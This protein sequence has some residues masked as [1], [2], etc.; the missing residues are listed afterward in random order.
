MRVVKTIKHLRQILSQARLK[1]QKIGFVPTMGYLHEGHLS[2]MRQARQE[3]AVCVVSI[4]VNP[5]QFG[6]HEDF[7]HYPRDIKRDATMVKKENVD[8][9]FIPSDNVIYSNSYLTYIDVEKMSDRLCGKYRPGHFKG[10]ATIVAK[11]LNMVRPDIMYLGQKDAQQVLIL[12][13]MVADLNFPVSIRVVPTVRAK[14]GLAISSRNV[15]LSSDQRLQAPVLYR[16][17]KSARVCVREGERRASYITG[18]IR[19]II[20]QY[21]DGKI[22]YVECVDAYTLEPLKMLKGKVLIAL[23]TTFGKT[24]LIDN[25]TVSVKKSKKI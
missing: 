16:A 18:M 12:R 23:S 9:L 22:Q 7:K 17:L 1:G 6:P 19:R 21:S 24:R 13:T 4:Y 11:L 15:Y 20:T 5:K 3:C 2:L 14:D 10:V 8:I 25:V